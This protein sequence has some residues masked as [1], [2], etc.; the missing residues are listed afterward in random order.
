MHDE[1]HRLDRLL[2]QLGS[3]LEVPGEQGDPAPEWTWQKLERLEDGMGRDALG[4]LL[5]RQ[6]MPRTAVEEALGVL[7]QRRAAQL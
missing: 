5:R 1:L 6:G 4:A 7:A 3:V 2:S